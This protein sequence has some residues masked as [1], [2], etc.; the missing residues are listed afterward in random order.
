MA[1]RES[2]YLWSITASSNGSIDP[3]VNFSELQLPSTL[4]N[5]NRAVLAAAARYLK[6]NNGTILTAGSANAYVA[7]TSET[8][9]AHSSGHM[10][11]FKANH[12]NTGSV[13]LAVTNADG[14]VLGS[15]AVRGPGDVALSAGQLVASGIYD[16]AYD[17]SANGAVGAWILKNPTHNFPSICGL[18]LTLTTGTPV[19]V[20]DVT[21]ATAVIATPASW[22]GKFVP[23]WD[24]AN[25]VPTSF[26]EVTQN[27]TDSTKSPAAAVANAIY[28]IYAWSDSG[29]ARISRSDYW[30]KSSTVTITNA[31][32]GVVTYSAHGAEN[33]TPC[34]LT[35]TGALPTGLTAG[36]TY[37]IVTSAT[38]T[39]ELAATVGGASINTSSAGSGTHT[40]T[41]GDDLGTVA[42]GSGGNCE[43]DYSTSGIALNK[44]AI[45]NG[46]GALR[47]TLLGGIRTDSSG[48]V[49]Y[50][51]G[52]AASGGDPA[53]LSVDNVYN[54]VEV[55]PEV[56]D[57][58]ATYTLTNSTVQPFHGS[59]SSDSGVGSGIGNRISILKCLQRDAVTVAFRGRGL[60]A[61]AHLANITIGFAKNSSTTDDVRATTLQVGSAVGIS[62]PMS[63]IKQYKPILGWNYFQLLHKGDG[64]NANTIVGTARE[65]GI[66]LRT[67]N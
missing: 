39:F 52:G 2:M 58:V 40:A 38:N 17:A 20:S 18:R 60:N 43:V 66:M 5:S 47:G 37:F 62:P 35:T 23:L 14:S 21:G 30:K 12:T 54:A 24:G 10:L 34:V 53:L 42:R 45:T 16:V 63:V 25:L 65:Q 67:R 59:N 36:T 13:T 22:A 3:S 50:K 26:G 41:I 11:G 55:A 44:N 4:N 33:G 56:S 19:M 7:T 8:W 1:E 27:L 9:S 31:S 57:T 15:K 49:T 48:T 64:T 6:D 51:L 46:P 28:D 61:A 32:P 29:T